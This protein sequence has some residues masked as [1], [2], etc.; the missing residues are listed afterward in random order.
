M[1]N[2]VVIKGTTYGFSVYMD[3]QADFATITKEVGDKF[4]ESAKFFGNAKMAISSMP[5]PMVMVS[6]FTQSRNA[7]VPIFFTE[8]LITMALI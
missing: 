8:P 3:E 1:N 4:K 5:S 7:L 6:A 2:A